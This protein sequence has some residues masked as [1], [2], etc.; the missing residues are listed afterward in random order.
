MKTDLVIDLDD[1]KRVLCNPNDS[2]MN[3]TLGSGICLVNLYVVMRATTVTMLVAQTCQ[4]ILLSKPAI[5]TP[6]GWQS[7]LRKVLE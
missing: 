2:M 3:E 4:C 1:L 6:E 7:L 5:P